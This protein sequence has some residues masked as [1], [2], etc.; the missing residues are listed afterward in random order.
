MSDG[1]GG[2]LVDGVE[3]CAK[4][5]VRLL[6][7]PGRAQQLGERGRERVREHFLLPRLLVNELALVKDLLADGHDRPAFSPESQDPVC[8]LALP[9]RD[10]HVH[11]RYERTEYVFCSEECKQRFLLTPEH[12]LR[13]YRK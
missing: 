13:A 5:I 9:P 12:Y 4:A 7:D 1:A 2:L 10:H 11:A 3:E 8:G 6:Q